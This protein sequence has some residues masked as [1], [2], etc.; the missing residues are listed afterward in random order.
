MLNQKISMHPD[1]Y[2]IQAAISVGFS[3]FSVCTSLLLE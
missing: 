3:A 1:T 2:W